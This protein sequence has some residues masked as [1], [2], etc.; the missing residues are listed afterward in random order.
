VGELGD[1]EDSVD[2]LSRLFPLMEA[3]IAASIS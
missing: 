1:N 3:F 2:K